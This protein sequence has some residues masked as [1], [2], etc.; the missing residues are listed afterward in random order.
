[1][2]PIVAYVRWIIVQLGFVVR[3]LLRPNREAVSRVAWIVVITVIPVVGVIAYLFVD[4]TSIGR[5]RIARA[6]EVLADDD[7]FL[8]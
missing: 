7:R 6:R 8:S 2:W 3:V 4:E 1:M 5:K